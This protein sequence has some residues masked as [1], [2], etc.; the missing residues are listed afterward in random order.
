MKTRHPIG[1]CAASIAALLF[2]STFVLAHPM[3]YQGTVLS[4][5]ATKLQVK[6]VDD[7]T[8]KEESV[9]F[10]VGKSTKVKRGDKTVAYADAK[11]AAGERVVVI[12]D[13]DADT[14]MLAEEIRLVAK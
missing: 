2:V 13:M 1:V 9:W 12:V 4:V 8:R 10:A 7:K 3:T 5:Q 6:A 14:K 11:I